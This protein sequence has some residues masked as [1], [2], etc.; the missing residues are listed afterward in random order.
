MAPDPRERFARV[1]DIGAP[2]PPAR[3]PGRRA[4]TLVA[5]AL[6]LSLATVVAIYIVA[7]RTRGTGLGGGDP[8]GES[9]AALARRPVRPLQRV[10]T[11]TGCS[12]DMVRVADRFCIDR[13]E[14]GV[15][16][17]LQERPLSPHYPPTPALLEKARRQWEERMQQGTTGANLP[18]PALPD[19]QKSPTWRPRAVS[20]PGLVPQGYVTQVA[21][22]ASCASAGKRLCTADEWRTACRGENETDFPYGRRHQPG[23]CNVAR[24]EHPAHLLKIDFTEALLDPRMNMVP[25]REGPLLRLT[26]ATATCASRWGDD[27]VYDMVGN[28][29]EWSGDPA[30][31]LLGGYYARETREGCASAITRHVPTF[32]NFST[33]FRCC[34]RLR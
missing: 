32:S 2:A 21:A 5:G 13:H 28:L 25:G 31:A 1:E 8:A 3:G 26:G 6:G 20:R 11:A 4:R 18:P 27:A 19:W 29:D 10:F 16:D 34:D 14:A 33:G 15:V 23:A 9:A 17:D 12:A 30:P 7:G 24:G 22:A